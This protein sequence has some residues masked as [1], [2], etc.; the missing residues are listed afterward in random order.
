[1]SLL[2]CCKAHS[3]WLLLPLAALH[4]NC[5]CVTSKIRLTKSRVKMSRADRNPWLEKMILPKLLG[6]TG[7]TDVF[8]Q[9][10]FPF[11]KYIGDCNTH[12]LAVFEMYFIIK[13]VFYK[14]MYIINATATV[15]NTCKNL[16]DFCQREA[17]CLFMLVTN[18][19]E[20]SIIYSK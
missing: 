3:D 2:A 12:V 19:G 20:H 5:H 15:I 7:N 13:R 17:I 11:L 10:S 6:K 18:K 8:T 4:I 1:M 16:F 14:Y 9:N